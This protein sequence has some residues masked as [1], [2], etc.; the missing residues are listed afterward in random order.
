MIK[1]KAEDMMKV[2][3]QDGWSSGFEVTDYGLEFRVFDEKGFE[4]A[5]IRYPPADAKAIQSF[6]EESTSRWDK[7]EI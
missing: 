2:E 4:R 1:N 3:L 7:D 5:F 6:L